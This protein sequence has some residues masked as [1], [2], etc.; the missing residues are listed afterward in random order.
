MKAQADGEVMTHL[1]CFLHELHGIIL[2]HVRL[3]FLSEERPRQH[4]AIT[5]H[6][7]TNTVSET[8]IMIGV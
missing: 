1:E 4:V 7:Y 3:V 2:T 8:A 6:S 5:C